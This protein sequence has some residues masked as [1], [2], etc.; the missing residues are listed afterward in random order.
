MYDQKPR[1]SDRGLVH[2]LGIRTD[3]LDGLVRHMNANGVVFRKD[4]ID[5]ESF[6]YVMFEA[7]DGVLVELYEVKVGSEW[8]TG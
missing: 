7:P 6:R 5:A 2:H 3:D 1:S 8:M 4:V